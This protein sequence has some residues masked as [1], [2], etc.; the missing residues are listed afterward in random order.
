M[1]IFLLLLLLFA[2]GCQ[3]LGGSK[4][5]GENPSD[6]GRAASGPEH[7][8]EDQQAI[9][10]P[11]D[12]PP[13]ESAPPPDAEILPDELSGRLD[14][15]ALSDALALQQIQEALQQIQEAQQLIQEVQQQVQETQEVQE[16]QETQETQQQVEEEPQQAG[17][18][19]A[20]EDPDAAQA[21][22]TEPAEEAAQAEQTEPAEGAAQT[23]QAEP[24]EGAV[25]T[26]QTAQ[27]DQA[28]LTDLWERI[29]SGLKLPLPT[30]RPEVLYYI[31]RMSQNPALLDQYLRRSHRYLHHI[32]NEVEAAGM[33]MEVA[34]LPIIESALNPRAYSHAAASGMWQFIY[35]TA[36]AQGMVYN[37]WVDERRSVLGSTK[38]GIGFLNQLHN[39]FDDWWLAFAA[40]NGGPARIR[41]AINAY[42]SRSYWEI[43]LLEETRGYVPKIIAMAHIIKYPELFGVSLP[44][45][46]DEPYFRALPVKQQIDLEKLAKLAGIDTNEMLQMNAQYRRRITPP[47]EEEH[48]V[49]VPI[50]RYEAAEKNLEAARFDARIGASPKSIA[51]RVQRGETLAQI[52]ARHGTTAEILRKLNN[53]SSNRI[54]RRQ[55]LVIPFSEDMIIYTVRRGDSLS[56]IGSRY[57][58]SASQLA[59]YNGISVRSPIQPGQQLR[60]TRPKG[61]GRGLRHT[62]RKGQSLSRIARRYG[63]STANLKAWNGLRRNTIHPGQVLLI[64]P[65]AQASQHIVRRGETLSGIA[66]RY[67]VSLANLRRINGLSSDV[68][69][70]GQR[71]RLK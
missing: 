47:G 7:T 55:R 3:M 11:F 23:D 24:V 56:R 46:P 51:Y 40:Y 68:I 15:S 20:S 48:L 33:P 22:Q 66:K 5:D 6:D 34:L 32:V 39:K 1:R 71:L 27:T 25:Q 26:T 52:A 61:A 30:N 14:D 49:L 35:S 36:R 17:E 8:H 18:Q 16:D 41:G 65:P 45:V 2:T 37:W 31:S 38:H 64:Y 57:G 60:I 29:R 54:R 12:H 63:V 21:E 53:L 44:A 9:A 10:H 4:A 67:R 69:Q 19:T 13:D 42:E 59:S 50:P 28:E 62:V 58:L 43:P 70:V